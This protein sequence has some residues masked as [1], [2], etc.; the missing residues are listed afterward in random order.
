MRIFVL[1]IAAR[2]SEAHRA[3]SRFLCTNRN[4]LT[5][6]FGSENWFLISLRYKDVMR[7]LRMAERE[8]VPAGGG[9]SPP[10][11]GD[12]GGYARPAR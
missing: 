1:K 11:P 9:S 6:W 4:A 3:T 2:V 12:L 5:S 10:H 7:S 8:S